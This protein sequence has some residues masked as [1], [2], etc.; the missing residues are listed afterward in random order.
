M[1]LYDAAQFGSRFFW[2]VGVIL[3]KRHFDPVQRPLFAWS[4]N[5]DVNCQLPAYWATEGSILGSG[6]DL[7]WNVTPCRW[8]N[9]Y[10]LLKGL[11]AFSF[12][13]TSLASNQP[14][15]SST[16]PMRTSYLADSTLFSNLLV[17]CIYSTMFTDM[18]FSIRHHQICCHNT[19]LFTE[20]EDFVN[21]TMNL[22]VPQYT[23]H[24]LTSWVTIG[25]DDN[26]ASYLRKR[27]SSIGFCKILRTRSY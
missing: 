3:E 20:A 25:L 9:S 14:W 11:R 21:T 8:V 2:N 19:H 6:K 7:F 16:T 26:D 10:W 27:T 17:E 22:Q 15:I 12:V 5:W 23:E 1:Y 24:F 4:Y 18:T 13:R